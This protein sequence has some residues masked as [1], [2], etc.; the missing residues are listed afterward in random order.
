MIYKRRIKI[1]KGKE[2]LELKW[3]ELGGI[4]ERSKWASTS[5]LKQVPHRTVMVNL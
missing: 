2:I 5:T 4:L 3:T 1:K